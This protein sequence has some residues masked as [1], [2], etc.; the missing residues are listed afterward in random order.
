MDYTNTAGDRGRRGRGPGRGSGRGHGGPRDSRDSR[1]DANSATPANPYRHGNDNNRRD[2]FALQ[3]NL[4]RLG[5]RFDDLTRQLDEKQSEFLALNT[6]HDILRDQYK[7]LLAQHNLSK[8]E[9]QKE[10]AAM[11]I[12]QEN[13]KLEFKEKEA[14]VAERMAELYKFTNKPRTLND[15][16]IMKYLN[17]NAD[18]FYELLRVQVAKTDAVREELAAVTQENA[19]LRTRLDSLG[20]G[21]SK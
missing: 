11:N 12:C 1:D 13:M 15:P 5:Q 4:A 8:E 18:F 9:H 2:L 3:E 20:G 7:Q 17:D 14:M 6:S 16:D 21:A 19:E 10:L